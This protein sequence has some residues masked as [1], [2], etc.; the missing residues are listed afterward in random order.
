M[1]CEKPG[2]RQLP[3]DSPSSGGAV[4]PLE[5]HPREQREELDSGNGPD[6]DDPGPKAA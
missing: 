3:E 6:D 1:T 2:S 5:R 4:I